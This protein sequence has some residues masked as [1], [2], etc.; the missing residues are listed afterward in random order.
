MN[1]KLALFL[2]S[3]GLVACPPKAPPPGPAVE[4][5]PIELF[6]RAAVESAPGPASA[7]FDL[8]LRTPDQQVNAQGALVVAPPNRFR[9]EVRGPIGPPQLVIV[10]D[11][12]G[13]RAWV[14]G[15]N[16]LYDAPDADARFRSY[17]GDAAG[18]DALSSLLLGRLPVR[19]KPDAVRP[20][21]PPGY[22]WDGPEQSH[23]DV[24]LAPTTGRV[25]G[26]TLVDPAGVSLVEADVEASEW[27]A[28]LVVRLPAQGVEAELRF[29]EWRAATPGDAAFVLTPPPGAEVV[30]LKLGGAPVDPEVPA[31]APPARG[32]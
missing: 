5:D 17:T 13:M 30:P 12:V 2:L 18:L 29:G 20:G 15:K 8:R 14:A 9:V 1:W 3:L 31:D 25:S 16:Q 23:L 26:L 11:G 7:S 27:P 4:V 32:G 22:R 10:S 6:E 19:E 21:D 28:R 24:S